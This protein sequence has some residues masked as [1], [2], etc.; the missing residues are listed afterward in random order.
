VRLPN[1]FS[2]FFF[3]KENYNQVRNHRNT[4]IISNIMSEILNKQIEINYLQDMK[5]V[6]IVRERKTSFSTFALTIQH[7]RSYS[8][9]MLN[10]HTK[11]LEDVSA[12]FIFS[13]LHTR[14]IGN[15]RLAGPTQLC[16]Y[17][18]YQ[19]VTILFLYNLCAFKKN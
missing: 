15:L 10:E 3:I 16:Y 7:Y 18:L 14:N 2:S 17:F 1:F 5:D 19:L 4:S 13:L 8:W 12:L 9:G 6:C 11:I